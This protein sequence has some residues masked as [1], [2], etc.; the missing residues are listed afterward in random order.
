MSLKKLLG[1]GRP[2]LV[3]PDALSG[4][5]RTA[6]DA[7]ARH[8]DHPAFAEHH[9]A[10]NAV[11]AATSGTSAPPKAGSFMEYL[12][13]TRAKP[14]TVGTAAIV[15][16]SGPIGKNLPEFEKDLG[17]CDLN[18][19][20]EWF[21][22][23]LGNPSV[24]RIL[25]DMNTPGGSVCGVPE[26]ASMVRASSKPVYAFTSEL[27]ASA[28]Y[29]IASQ[30]RAVYATPSSS[31]GSIGV[32]VAYPDLSGMYEQFGIKV[33]VIKSGD[34]KGAGIPG[35][36]LSDAQRQ[37]IQEEVV[38]LHEQ[39]MSAVTGVRTSVKKDS[40]RGQCFY[41]S[42]AASRGLVTGIVQNRAEVLAKITR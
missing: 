42:D 1:S 20:M 38:A 29:W 14:S 23:A 25:L 6:E 31:V 13:G 17:C 21:Q 35:T 16:V 12:F 10:V 8:R 26:F 32:Y 39:F 30:A 33:D 9:G 7:L 36:S 19:A 37:Q 22:A 41:G 27:C 40:M 18:D 15:P 5:F 4:H 24:E 2:I 28:G 34:L 3:H 11:L